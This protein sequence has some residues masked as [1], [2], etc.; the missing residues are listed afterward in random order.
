MTEKNRN[1]NQKKIE[2]GLLL[3]RKELNDQSKIIE[4]LYK[5]N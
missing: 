3:H 5:R 2:K 1:R 4:A